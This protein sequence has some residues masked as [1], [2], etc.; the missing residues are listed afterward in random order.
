MSTSLTEDAAR[1]LAERRG[2]SIRFDR[3]QQEATFGYRRSGVR[4]EVWFSNPRA[5][6]RRTRF[7][8][9]RGFSGAVYWAAGL[10]MSGTWAWVLG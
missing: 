3:R 7:A 8:R 2:R 10:E 6:A 5:V 1:A 4:H 9:Q